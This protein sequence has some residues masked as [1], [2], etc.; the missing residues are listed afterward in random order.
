[1][2]RY[3]GT[4]KRL[5]MSSIL[6][7]AER[8]GDRSLGFGQHRSDDLINQGCTVWQRIGAFDGNGGAQDIVGRNGSALPAEFVTT[9]RPA[10]TSRM[11][12]RTRAC[13]TGSRCRGGSRCR[14]ANAF[15]ET[16]RARALMATSITAAMARRPLRDING[17]WGTTK[18]GTRD[19]GIRLHPAM[20]L[21]TNGGGC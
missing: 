11:P 21:A 9:V 12:S 1:M 18:G 6:I 5:T 3:F 10:D 7:S 20:R 4:A 17:I 14:A 19:S 15:A 13:R 8:H 16:G 2:A